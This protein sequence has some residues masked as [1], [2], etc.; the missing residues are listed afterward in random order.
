M[1]GEDMRRLSIDYSCQRGTLAQDRGMHGPRALQENHGNSQCPAENA[2]VHRQPSH[3]SKQTEMDLAYR[4]AGH[5]RATNEKV[6]AQSTPND[7]GLTRSVGTN[8]GSFANPYPRQ[9]MRKQTVG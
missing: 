8:E 1:G 9:T 7:M 5:F 4:S 3:S 2:H 6:R